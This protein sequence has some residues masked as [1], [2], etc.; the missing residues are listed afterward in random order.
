MTLLALAISTIVLAGPNPKLLVN[1]QWLN[2]HK[3]DKNLVVLHAAMRADEYDNG[4]VPGARLVLW[5]EYVLDG[6]KIYSELPPV[7]QLKAT[8]EAAGV[9]DNSTVV[10]YGD[11]LIAARA[12]MT[13]EYLGHRDVRLLNGGV[14][15]W[16]QAG[17][18]LSTE[19]FKSAPGK[20]TP[21]LRSFVVD[22]E[23]VNANRTKPKYMLLDAR[24]VNEFTGSDKGHDDHA[25][26]HI[27]GAQN[28]YWQRFLKSREEPFLIPDTE[29][30]GLFE[31][32]GATNDK[33]VIV[34]CMLGMR[35]SFAYFVSRYLGYDTR[36]Y[37]G[38]WLDWAARK[39]PAETGGEPVK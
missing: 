10:V 15:G 12:F 14:T 30:R 25:V 20:L 39:L 35:A 28:V 5:K 16:K 38:S 23:W 2:E 21:K 34:Y 11:P 1:A 27:P 32:A 36:F 3:N 22:A 8:F 31:R 29:L 6:E 26:G 19:P 7:E 37:D 18:A 33:T 13:L 24:P 17:F 9:N 4:H